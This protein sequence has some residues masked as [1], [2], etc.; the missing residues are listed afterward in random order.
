MVKWPISHEICFMACRSFCQAQL[1]PS[2]RLQPKL[3]E[4]SLIFH[5]ISP[6]PPA[7][8][9]QLSHVSSSSPQ[10]A[11]IILKIIFNPELTLTIIGSSKLVGSSPPAWWRSNIYENTHGWFLSLSSLETILSKTLCLTKTSVGQFCSLCEK[12]E[13]EENY[14][15]KMAIFGVKGGVQKNFRSIL[16][17]FLV[18]SDN[19]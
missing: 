19:R 3:A 11:K 15:K 14:A 8:R 9:F 18:I 10:L 13:G 2:C 12:F 4:H 17:P 7:V 6:P 5:F 16:S 1:S